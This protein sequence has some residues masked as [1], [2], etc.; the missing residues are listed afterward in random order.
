MNVP[1]F[2]VTIFLKTL[3]TNFDET[4]R[5]LSRLPKDATETFSLNSIHKQKFFINNNFFITV[6]SE[7]VRIC[8]PCPDLCPSK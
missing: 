2:L 8:I 4:F 3:P 6:V 5:V 7:Y 1:L